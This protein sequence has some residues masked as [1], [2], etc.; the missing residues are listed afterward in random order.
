MTQGNPNTEGQIYRMP[1]MTDYMISRYSDARLREG[2]L[3][4]CLEHSGDCCY[5]WGRLCYKTITQSTSNDLPVKLIYKYYD[6]DLIFQ[7]YAASEEWGILQTPLTHKQML[8]ALIAM[9]LSHRTGI[10]IPLSLE[11]KK[12]YLAER[13]RMRVEATGRGSYNNTDE[14]LTDRLDD[15]WPEPK[16]TEMYK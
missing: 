14:E 6:I 9:N 1:E 4:L 3:M 8:G 2:D 11:E 10:L 16:E 12:Q 7:A 5:Y 15:K 13:D